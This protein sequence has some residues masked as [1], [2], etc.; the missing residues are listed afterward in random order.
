MPVSEL[1]QIDNELL[2]FLSH[3]GENCLGVC[4]SQAWGVQVADRHGGLYGE[5]RSSQF[6]ELLAPG[7]GGFHPGAFSLVKG[8]MV[9]STWKWQVGHWQSQASDLL[10]PLG[11]M[12]GITHGLWDQAGQ[13]TLRV[14]LPG[15][16]D[17]RQVA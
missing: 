4:L 15:M 14:C 7:N 8:G 11:V 13:V 6:R 2:L 3:H 17:F 9:E 12:D 5:V 16:G 10:G 1:T